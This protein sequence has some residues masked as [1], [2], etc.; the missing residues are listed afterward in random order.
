VE[1]TNSDHQFVIEFRMAIERYLCAVDEWVSAS[2]NCYLLSGYPAV[3][4]EEVEGQQLVYQ[5]CRRDLEAMLPR[6]RQLC[7]R[8]RRS[9]P[10]EELLKVGAENGES[11][12]ARSVRAAVSR[13]LIE[14]HAACTRPEWVTL[15]QL[16]RGAFIQ[17]LVSLLS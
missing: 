13:A 9:D 5:M 12:I 14:L 10:F 6:A 4:V 11:G 8:Y 2:R 1:G 16:F 7:S 15:P 3:G 17:R